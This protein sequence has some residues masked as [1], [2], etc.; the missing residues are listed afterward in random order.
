HPLKIHFSPPYDFGCDLCRKPS[1]KGWLYRCRFCEFDAHIGCAISQRIGGGRISSSGREALDLLRLRLGIE[2]KLGTAEAEADLEEEILSP[3]MLCTPK[4]DKSAIWGSRVSSVTEIPSYQFS[5][6]CFSI[7]LHKSYS[8]GNGA[9]VGGE[10]KEE[11][12]AAAVDSGRSEGG[13]KNYCDSQQL[14]NSGKPTTKVYGI[15]AGGGGGGK[16]NGGIDEAVED[17]NCSC[18]RRLLMLCCSCREYK[19][20]SS[21]SSG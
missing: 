15:H 12:A 18:W 3:L 4:S 11:E 7:D 5:D 17:A 6:M 14:L 16:K 13:S 20:C 21:C 8:D 19:K 10:M 1:Y 9:V 2:R